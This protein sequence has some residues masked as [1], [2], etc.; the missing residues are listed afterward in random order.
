MPCLERLE[1]FGLVQSSS[2][3]QLRQPSPE[4]LWTSKRSERIVVSVF[5]LGL[6]LLGPGGFRGSG[7]CTRDRDGLLLIAG[8]M[9]QLP[10]MLG[11]IPRDGVAQL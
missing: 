5:S 7:L 2:R 8:R 4:K 11:A 9:Q 3:R 10:V 1:F 6:A